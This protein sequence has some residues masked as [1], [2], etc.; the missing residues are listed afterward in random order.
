[1]ATPKLAYLCVSESWGGLEMNQ[2]RNAYWM[3]N[4]G[5]HVLLIVLK[6]TPIAVE[7]EQL[8]I[9]TIAILSYRKYYP[10]KRA[11]QLSKLFREKEVSHLIIRDPKD[12][13]LGSTL[14]TFLKNE[15]HLSYFM[16][17][18]L[19]IDKKDLLHTIRFSKLD[20]WSCPLPWLA[21]QVR[22]R[23]RFPKERIEIIPS[24]LD[25]SPFTQLP[26]QQD[27]RGLLKLPKEKMI[28]GLIGRFDQQKGQLL[29]L[30]AYQKLPM[31]DREKALLLFLGEKTK[32]EADEY[33]IEL[34]QFI[35]NNKLE[36]NVFIQPF[37]RDVLPFYAA[38][39]WLVMASSSETFGM[40]TIEALASGKPV[41]GSN[42]GGTPEILEKGKLGLLFEPENSE[43]L[44]HQLKKAIDQITTNGIPQKK[45][46]QS[47]D[48]SAVCVR[49]EK[50][51]VL[52]EMSM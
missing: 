14:K 43:S 5:H 49:V 2:L 52:G 24:G 28:F 47:Y 16:E 22:T 4:R 48:H 31:E 15:L 37:R 36:K 13:S 30:E 7:A 19:G 6:S 34:Q 3:K 44:T 32:N 11:F 23:T 35:A 39:D 10:I 26:S 41:I 8:K 51:L 40:V 27:A 18:Q 9:P 17:M 46:A 20:L 21:K 33:C 12:I 29:L 45:A 50:A 25:L 1:M 42:A 38:I